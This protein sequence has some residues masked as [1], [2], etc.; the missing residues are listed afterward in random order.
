[1]RSYKEPFVGRFVDMFSAESDP[2]NLRM[3]FP[4]PPELGTI[5]VWPTTEIG[6]PSPDAI[7]NGASKV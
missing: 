3:P 6:E 7:T 1:L 2:E 4:N 5:N